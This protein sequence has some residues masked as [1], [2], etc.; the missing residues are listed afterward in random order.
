M[1]ARERSFVIEAHAIDESF[2][3]KKVNVAGI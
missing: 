3:S 2:G 1:Q